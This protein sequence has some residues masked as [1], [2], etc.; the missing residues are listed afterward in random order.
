MELL[1]SL[2]LT[3]RLWNIRLYYSSWDPFLLLCNSEF[4]FVDLLHLDAINAL[5]EKLILKVNAGFLGPQ[6]DLTTMIL[7][8]WVNNL[9]LCLC[10]WHYLHLTHY[11]PAYRLIKEQA[12]QNHSVLES[13][14]STFSSMFWTFF[15]LKISAMV[16]FFFLHNHR[17]SVEG[18]RALAQSPVLATNLNFLQGKAPTSQSHCLDTPQCNHLYSN[19]FLR[20]CSQ[21]FISKTTE[22]AANVQY[23]YLWSWS[24]HENV[25]K[26][27]VRKYTEAHRIYYSK[28]MG[29][30]I[31]LQFHTFLQS[32]FAIKHTWF[33][34]PGWFDD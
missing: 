31:Y 25:R 4:L 33:P 2:K 21:A 12:L 3:R 28:P 34:I 23:T 13:F 14:W 32:I 19:S 27:W 9:S 11:I 10:H 8:F 7:R 20:G 1:P 22:Q 26:G 29:V 17:V 24:W 5:T 16:F 30:E 18:Q 6:M 15:Y